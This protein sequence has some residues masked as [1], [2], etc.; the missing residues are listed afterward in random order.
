MQ[1]KEVKVPG[2]C[3]GK[4]RDCIQHKYLHWCTVPSCDN[5]MARL[6]TSSLRSK[7]TLLGYIS[8]LVLVYDQVQDQVGCSSEQPSLVEDVPAHGRGVG[9]R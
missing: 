1:H 8:P 6:L 9:T 4:E 2:L 3:V 7:E 5:M